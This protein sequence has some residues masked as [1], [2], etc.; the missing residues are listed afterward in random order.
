MSST[1]NLLAAV[2]DDLGS[3]NIVAHELCLKVQ[4][5]NGEV[6]AGIVSITEDARPS[7]VVKN[8]WETAK[9]NINYLE[10]VGLALR[11]QKAKVYMEPIPL[12]SVGRTPRRRPPLGPSANGIPSFQGD[13]QRPR[14]EAD[15]TDALKLPEL[16]D[17]DADA[18]ITKYHDLYAGNR[19]IL[20][21][22]SFDKS[23]FSKNWSYCGVPQWRVASRL[24]RL[25]TRFFARGEPAPYNIGY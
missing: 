18:F 5:I 17:A 2:I 7:E 25:L 9:D 4:H 12:V 23:A 1:E 22:I 20:I 8:L 16:L 13:G 15:L 6:D 10:K 11:L 24:P 21:K 3:H 19:A 14:H